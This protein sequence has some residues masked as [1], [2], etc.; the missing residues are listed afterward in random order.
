MRFDSGQVFLRITTRRARHN[1][2]IRLLIF[3]AIQ[4]LGL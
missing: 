4:N 1:W 3:L 2:G